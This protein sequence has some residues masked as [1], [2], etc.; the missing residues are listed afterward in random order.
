MFFAAEKKKTKNKTTNK[1]KK[2]SKTSKK[3]ASKKAS[4]KKKNHK[5]KF[6]FKQV[7]HHE[8]A[9]KK[10][11]KRNKK[12]KNKT[13]R[14]KTEEKAQDDKGKTAF[15]SDKDE[16]HHSSI[17]SRSQTKT[18]ARKISSKLQKYMM[19]G[20]SALRDLEV[21]VRRAS[22]ED[23][24]AAMDLVKEVLYVLHQLLRGLYFLSPE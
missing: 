8:K 18:K 1:N 13:D 21:G 9:K 4:A 5:K 11:D 10:D 7:P 12:N 24:E 17:V 22:Q 2:S 3:K 15:G 16:K 14:S 23:K 6:M 20:K 19:M